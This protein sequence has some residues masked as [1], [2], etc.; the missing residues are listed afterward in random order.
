MRFS[1]HVQVNTWGRSQHSL[2][3][4]ARRYLQTQ[5]QV[6]INHFQVN[7]VVLDRQFIP[8]EA[9]TLQR[10]VCVTQKPLEEES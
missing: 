3:L 1:L 6:N 2:N 8:K 5:P 9:E 7:T 10:E 4:L